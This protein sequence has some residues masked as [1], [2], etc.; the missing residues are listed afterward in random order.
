MIVSAKSSF[1]NV[2]WMLSPHEALLDF[3]QGSATVRIRYHFVGQSLFLAL[4]CVLDIV[5]LHSLV[6]TN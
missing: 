2:Y 3:Q 1:S 4:F 6:T 5:S